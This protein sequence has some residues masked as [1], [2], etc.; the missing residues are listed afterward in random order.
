MQVNVAD[1]G[2]DIPP[3]ERNRVFEAFRRGINQVEGLGKGAGLGLA[4]CKGLVEAHGGH[5][6]IKKKNTPGATISFTIPLV[7]LHSPGISAGKEK[8]AEEE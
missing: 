6:W 1:Q 5:I 7:P 4:I 8:L 3:E 2:P